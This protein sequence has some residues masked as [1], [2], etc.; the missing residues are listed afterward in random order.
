MIEVKNLVK[1]YGKNTAVNDISFTVN[2]GEILGFLGPNGAG[3][4][5]TMNILTGY[6]SSTSGQVII[7]GHDILDEPNEAKRHIGYLPEH[8]PLYKD[9]TVEEYLNFIY[10]LKKVKLKRYDHLK[11]ICELVKIDNVYGRMIKHLSKGYQQRVGVAQALIGNPEVLILDEPTVG[12]DPRQIIE[13][14]NLIKQLGKNH[15]VIFSTHILSEVQAVCERILVINKGDIVADD[16]PDELSARLSNETK[17]LVRIAGPQDQILSAIRK[18]EGVTDVTLQ[19]IKER[20]TADFLVE[21]KEGVD[22]RIPLFEVLRENDW[23][24]MGLKSTELN[25][26][27]IFIKLTADESEKAATEKKEKAE[28][29]KRSGRKSNEKL[30]F[31]GEL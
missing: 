28:K 3:K 26:E 19:G 29:R 8:P 9:M 16:T 13:I 18:I 4:T 2:D 5:T 20:G 6:L 30:S 12:L 23:P 15:T 25:L 22:I 1:R 10:D 14:R 17:R 27:D 24:L 11:E 31:D 21:S 7:N